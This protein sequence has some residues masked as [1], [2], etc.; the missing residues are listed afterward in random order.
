MRVRYHGPH[1]GVR[2]PVPGSRDVEV[3]RGDEIEVSDPLGRSL[4]EQ[5]D[6]WEAV[7]EKPPKTGKPATTAAE[8]GD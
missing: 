6:N 7:T 4:L 2:L 8:K 5:P 1:D 3:A